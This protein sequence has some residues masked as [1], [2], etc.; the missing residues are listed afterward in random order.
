MTDGARDAEYF[1]SHCPR[2]CTRTEDA[3]CERDR[4]RLRERLANRARGVALL[5]VGAAPLFDM[6]GLTL[7]MGDGLALCSSGRRFGEGVDSHPHWQRRHWIID[8]GLC[9]NRQRG[10]SSAR[11]C[12]PA[13][14]RLLAV[15]ERCRLGTRL[16]WQE[17]ARIAVPGVRDCR[18]L[19]I[20]GADPAAGLEQVLL[21]PG[22]HLER[23]HALRRALFHMPRAELN[24]SF[25]FVSV[26]A[27]D[28][29]S[30]AL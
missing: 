15:H 6:R 2:I 18:L 3:S 10:L 23:V 19:G 17:P 30:R 14:G 8:P 11:R 22:A 5:E 24:G 4:E 27:D 28:R 26:A 16:F 25:L 21:A 9:I 12:D 7:R 13:P 29:T 1:E 20:R